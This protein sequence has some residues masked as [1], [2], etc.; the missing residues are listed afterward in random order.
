MVLAADEQEEDFERGDSDSERICFKKGVGHN[1]KIVLKSSFAAAFNSIINKQI[2]GEGND[3][4][5]ILAK[6][7]RP[8]KE[9][10]AELKKE[11]ELKQKRLEKEKIRLMG[12]HL[13]TV[14]DEDHEREL[15]V[16][17][18]KGGINLALI[19]IVVQLFNTVSEF[20]VTQHKEAL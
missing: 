6:Y 3:Q 8:A 15:Q 18:T 17:A 13:P 4:Q 16:V 7:K 20:Q 19:L 1:K 14:E 10:T 9:V 2:E 11:N 12:R 5:P